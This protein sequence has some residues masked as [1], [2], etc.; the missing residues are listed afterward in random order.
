MGRGPP[1]ARRRPRDRLPHPQRQRHADLRGRATA[2]DA[3][4]EEQTEFVG[5]VPPGQTIRR[6]APAEWLRSY[7]EPEPVQ[8][9]F[10]DSA[11]RRWTRDEQG[12]SPAQSRATNAA[13]SRGR[14]R[15]HRPRPT[16]SISGRAS[17]IDSAT[18]SPRRT[19]Q[20]SRP[21]VICTSTGS[22]VRAR[23]HVAVGQRVSQQAIHRANSAEQLVGQAPL[24][25]LDRPRR[26]GGPPGGTAGRRPARL[27][28]R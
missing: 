18:T 23:G 27:S 5:L 10:L 15:R 14:P 26:S 20:G 13:A 8:I 24:L 11:G 7:V 17:S 28:R 19:A 25:G 21:A 22:P 2:P 12:G 3:A 16:A 4:G 1:Q 9:E 6:R